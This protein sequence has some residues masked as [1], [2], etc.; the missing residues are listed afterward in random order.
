MYRYHPQIEKVVDLLK[1]KVI[2]NLVSMES[3]FGFD[4]LGAKKIF[5]IKLKKKP[6]YNLK[7][8]K[9]LKKLQLPLKVKKK[10][11]NFIIKNNFRS[12]SVK[13]SVRILKRKILKK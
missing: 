1:N 4:A 8:F 12:L 7:M 13:K 6:N 5:G 2:G 3:F 11:S 9:K 10:K